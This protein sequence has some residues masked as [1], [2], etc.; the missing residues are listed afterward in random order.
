MKSLQGQLLIA[1]PALRDPNF[2]KAVVLM[3][4]HNDE[5]ALGLI[6]NHPTSVLISEAWKQVSEAPCAQ[7]ERLLHGGPCEGPLM[8]VHVH[9]PV[10]Q[11]QVLSGVFFSTDKENVEWLLEQNH[12]PIKFFVGCA[13]WSGGQVESELEAGSWL[14]TPATFESIFHS[15]ED[16]WSNVTRKIARSMTLSSFDPKIIPDDPSMN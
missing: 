2:L 12:D 15:G 14:T 6:L 16:Q 11:V 7:K 3:V 9:E 5:G 13:G 4:Q 8:V 10:S 1:S